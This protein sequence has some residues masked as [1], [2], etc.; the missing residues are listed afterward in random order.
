V[1]KPYADEVAYIPEAYEWAFKQDIKKLKSTISRISAQPLISVG[2]GGSFT[3]A[4]F[5]SFLH[6]SITGKLST[7][8]TPYQLL[9][10]FNVIRNVGV[11]VLSAEGKNKD[12][13]GSFKYLLSTEPQ[14]LMALT[15]MPDSPLNALASESYY[16]SSLAYAMPWGKDGYLATNSLISTC[17]LLYRAYQ[18]CFSNSLPDCPDNVHSLLDECIELNETARDQFFERLDNTRGT[19]FLIITGLSGQ[20]AGVDLESRIS[21]SGLGTCQVVDFRSFAHG[22]HLW[23]SKNKT[24]TA[25]IV[26]WQEDEKRLLENFEKTVPISTPILSIKLKGRDYLKQ[27]A[28]T[29]LSVQLVKALGDRYGVDPGQPEVSTSGRKIYELDAFKDSSKLIMV[30]DAEWAVIRKF[31]G[32]HNYGEKVKT[33]FLEAYANYIVQ[34]TSTKFGAIVFDYDAV[35]ARLKLTRCAR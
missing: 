23:T 25:A 11:S 28:S 30:K 4:Y 18:A 7:A 24:N 20:I 9:S 32:A 10:K 21:E 35:G 17:V 31:G 33:D 16:A 22:R 8:C 27:L 12:V 1:G 19:N 26:L 2:S 14:D 15:L 34:L 6:E 13:L 5:Q 3:A 29:V